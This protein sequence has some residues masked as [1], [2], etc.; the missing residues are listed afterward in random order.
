MHSEQKKIREVVKE[1]ADSGY[2]V[3]VRPKDED[4]PSFLHGYAPDIIAK[5]GTQFIVIEVKSRM[6]LELQEELVEIS[7]RLE[8]KNNWRL[9]LIISKPRNTQPENE[10]IE[11]TISWPEIRKKAQEAGE[12]SYQGHKE[13]ALLLAWA[14]VEGALRRIAVNEKLLTKSKSTPELIKSLVTH[15]LISRSDYRNIE[16]WFKARNS[17]AHGY[18]PEKPDHAMT[19][20]VLKL[21][22]KLEREQTAAN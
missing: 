7:K 20:K 4:L 21:L 1:Y 5:K 22:P 9:D 13:A 10:S 15:G 17:I 16:D 2:E 12:L 18:L 8:G 3:L 14:A 19:D 6:T 11:R